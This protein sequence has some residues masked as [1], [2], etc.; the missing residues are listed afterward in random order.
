MDLSLP[1]IQKEV[2]KEMLKFSGK[3]EGDSIF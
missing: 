2:V 3:L 1:Q